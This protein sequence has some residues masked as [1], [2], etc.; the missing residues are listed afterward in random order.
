MTRRALPALLALALGGCAH[1]SQCLPGQVAVIES[2]LLVEAVSRMPGGVPGNG[3]NGFTLGRWIVVHPDAAEDAGLLCHEMKHVADYDSLGVL[4]F[5]EYSVE[6]LRH[7][8]DRNRFEIAADSAAARGCEIGLVEPGPGATPLDVRHGVHADS[9]VS[10]NSGRT[11]GAQP[12]ADR[13]DI[14]DPELGAS[15]RFSERTP[16][17]PLPVAIRSVVGVRAEEKVR[18]VHAGRVITV[19]AD[20][21]PSRD[22]TVVYLPG[23]ARRDG[24]PVL[25]IQSAVPRVV[26]APLPEPAAVRLFHPRPEPFF[27]RWAVT[28]LVRAIDTRPGG[29]RSSQPELAELRAESFEGAVQ[30]GGKF[31]V[32]HR[33]DVRAEES[34]FRLGPC[35]VIASNGHA[36][37]VTGAADSGGHGEISAG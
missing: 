9:V 35:S 30:C 10:G 5:L 25:S 20:E 31:P 11:F 28:Q 21:Q 16:T 13:P 18:R 4:F 14:L 19:M 24:I 23:H 7:G 29:A 3:V 34:M 22:R 26:D 15:G 6:T 32:G 2:E 27:E 17:S 1:A 12:V 8:Y 36:P 33:L 37:N